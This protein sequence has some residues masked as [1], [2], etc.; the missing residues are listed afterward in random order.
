MLVFRT[1]CPSK[2]T[3]RVVSQHLKKAP[4]RLLGRGRMRTVIRTRFYQIRISSSDPRRDAKVGRMSMDNR[5]S[6][7]THRAVDRL[8]N[9]DWKTQITTPSRLQF[10]SGSAA[11]PSGNGS[12]PKGP[13]S[14]PSPSP[15]SKTWLLH[16]GKK[17]VLSTAV[18]KAAVVA[19]MTCEK[20]GTHA[21]L[22]VL[23]LT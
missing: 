4:L 17:T 15:V 10:K 6:R 13:S 22:G 14:L 8:P 1:I 11:T 9:M 18:G 2:W 19:T 7:E 21:L 20:K 16:L 3:V 12:N 23:S 5:E